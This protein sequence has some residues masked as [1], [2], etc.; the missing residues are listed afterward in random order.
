V[1]LRA[2]ER[3]DLPRYVRWFNDPAVLEFFGPYAPLSLAAEERWFEEQLRD[4]SQRNFAIDLEG[5]HIGAGGFSHID[6]R[7]GCAEVGLF[8]GEPDLWDQGL[9][10]DAVR[11][12]VRFGFEEMNLHRIYLRVFE[13]N[14]RGV[15]CYEKIGFRREGLWRQAVFRHGRYY[16]LLWMSILRD[17]YSP[18]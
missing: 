4:S 5:R 18:A 1:V 17:E 8:I 6:P 11:T 3:D 15:N 13:E 7:N 16:D 14:Q 10:A 2:N 12:L 9:G